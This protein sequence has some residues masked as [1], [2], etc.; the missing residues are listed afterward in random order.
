MEFA[1]LRRDFDRMGNGMALFG[2]GKIYKNI[3]IYARIANRMSRKK[4]KP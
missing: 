3:Y 4:R 2:D 1:L